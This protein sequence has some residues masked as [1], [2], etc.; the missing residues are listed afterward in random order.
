MWPKVSPV[1]AHEHCVRACMCVLLVVVGIKWL[2]AIGQATPAMADPQR[3]GEVR[4]NPSIET[5]T[6]N[7]LATT[8]TLPLYFHAQLPLW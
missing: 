1:K 4:G 5:V 8:K 3:G 7:A 6:H 2:T